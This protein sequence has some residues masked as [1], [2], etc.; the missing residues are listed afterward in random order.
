MVSCFA[1]G[2]DTIVYKNLQQALVNP[3]QVYILELKRLKGD[4]FPMEILQFKNLESLN[5][6]KNSFRYVPE[7]I[8]QLKKL[9]YL[10]LSKNNL[11]RLPY[12]IG[13]LTNLEQLIVNQNVIEELPKS[14]GNLKKLEFLDLWSNEIDHFPDEI[15]Q[16]ESLK[17]IDMRGILMPDNKQADLKAKAPQAKIHLTPGCNCGH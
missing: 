17:I 3:D 5:L 2:Q 13:E 9:R 15:S 6:S 7:E 12:S 10:N 14:I 16:C 11:K 1:Y 4:E 8:G